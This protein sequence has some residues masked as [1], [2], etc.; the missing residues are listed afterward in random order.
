MANADDLGRL[1]QEVASAYEERVKSILDI[2]GY[3]ADFLAQT[4]EEIKDREIYIEN[5]LADF[6]DAREKMGRKL[7]AKLTGDEQ[8][9]KTETQAEIKEREV[10][11]ENLLADFDKAHQEMAQE[12]RA[13]LAGDE[14]TRKTETQAEIKERKETVRSML[15][16]FRK[17]QE[18][19]AAAWKELLAGMQSLREKVTIT[20]PA[21][22]EAAVEVTTVDEAIEVE[23]PEEAEPEEAEPEEAEPEEDLAEEEEPEEGLADRVIG[24]LEDHPD[25]L[26]M[27]EIADILGIES[28]RSL[29]PVMRQL[30]DDGEVRKENSTY[31]IA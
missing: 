4:R 18:E 27:V 10:Y 24:I 22:I 28:W 21:E 8:T 9:R 5:L 17:E 29:I 7:R 6:N 19:A 30:L 26:K 12:L 2:K 13:K 20:G 23:E 16:E 3:T 25:G 1:A 14:Q 15:D 31:F 11:I